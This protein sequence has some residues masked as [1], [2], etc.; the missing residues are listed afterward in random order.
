LQCQEQIVLGP[1]SARI[2]DQ[3]RMGDDLLSATDETKATRMHGLEMRASRHHGNRRA[4]SL[5][6]RR[7]IAAD[8]TGAENGDA[9]HADTSASPSFWA[10]PTRC[11]LPVA[12]FGISARKRIRL[13]TLKSAIRSDAKA[14]NSLSLTFAPSRSTTTAATSSPS[15]SCGMAKVTTC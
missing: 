14:R 3:A 10:R 4:R 8:G 13:G 12:P 11:S 7:Q 5:E 9:G 2:V 6:P 15:L 1:C